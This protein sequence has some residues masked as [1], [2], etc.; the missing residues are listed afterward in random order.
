MVVFKKWRREWGTVSL[1]AGPGGKKWTATG[2][3]CL[4]L[5]RRYNTLDLAGKVSVPRDCGPFGI[6]KEGERRRLGDETAASRSGVR[7]GRF[8]PSLPA[9]GSHF[10]RMVLE[11]RSGVWGNG[12]A[13]LSAKVVLPT[14]ALSA[15]LRNS[16]KCR[17]PERSASGLRAGALPSAHPAGVATLHPAQRQEAMLLTAWLP[18]LRGWCAEVRFGV[19]G[20]ARYGE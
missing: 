16:A 15:F 8:R 11:I 19:A 7:R 9:E 13:A 17:G 1:H 6:P 2:R 3:V 14:M 5:A 18:A 4:S 12:G 20:V 10:W